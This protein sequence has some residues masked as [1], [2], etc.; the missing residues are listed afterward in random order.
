M[1]HIPTSEGA[2]AR[3]IAR[4]GILGVFVSAPSWAIPT[5]IAEKILL[6]KVSASPMLASKSA[7]LV[8]VTTTGDSKI[9]DVSVLPTAL[10]YCE[11]SSTN[12]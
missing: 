10:S 4:T 1:P 6:D 12:L 5:I 11:S 8:A 2:E 7:M 3:V 9:A